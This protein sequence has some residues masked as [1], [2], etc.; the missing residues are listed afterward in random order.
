VTRARLTWLAIALVVT[1][2]L[3]VGA[4]GRGGHET[5]AAR[6]NRIASSIRCPTCRGLSAAESDA[7]ASIAIRDEIRRRVHDGETDDQIRDFLAS[8]Y[9][10]DIRLVPP[11]SGIGA[12][13]WVLPAIAFATGAGALALAFSRWRR[14]ARRGATDEDE[15]IVAAA[16]AP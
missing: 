9:G 10:D 3:F 13:V 14:V 4:R 8:R 7:R 15:R 5:E 2:A 12:V 16:R 1:A 11:S 6:A